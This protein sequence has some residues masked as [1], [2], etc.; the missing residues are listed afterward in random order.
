MLCKMLLM[1]EHLDTEV[2]SRTYLSLCCSLSGLKSTGSV[3]LLT[4]LHFRTS[5][6]PYLLHTKYLCASNGRASLHTSTQHTEQ[7]HRK[8]KVSVHDEQ[9]TNANNSTGWLFQQNYSPSFY[10]P[11]TLLLPAPFSLKLPRSIQRIHPLMFVIHRNPSGFEMHLQRM[12]VKL[13]PLTGEIETAHLVFF[14]PTAVTQKKSPSSCLSHTHPSLPV[15][16]LVSN[17]QN[18][19]FSNYVTLQPLTDMSAI[20]T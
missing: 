11:L 17:S 12:T 14:T 16:R 20:L 1:N 18:I 4:C 15:S 3:H 7:A 9:Q 6:L 2:P 19:S 10:T 5:S 8:N 13:S